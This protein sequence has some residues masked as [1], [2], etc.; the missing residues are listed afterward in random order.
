M[1]IEEFRVWLEQQRQSRKSIANH[2]SQVERIHDCYGDLDEHF[3]ADRLEGVLEDMK[4]SSADRR[5]NRPNPT[6]MKIDGNIYN[7]LVTYRAS[8]NL[9]RRFREQSISACSDSSDRSKDG[10]GG[11]A[12]LVTSATRR[13]AL[14]PP[15]TS[16][17]GG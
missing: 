13:E 11:S 1:L 3:A 14:Q 9:Y 8:I 4:Y 10:P 12:R 7:T 16:P 2:C 6:P 15:L 17:D 5:A